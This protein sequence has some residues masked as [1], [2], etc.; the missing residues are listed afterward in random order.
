MVFNLAKL[1][2]GILRKS[3]TRLELNKKVQLM[4]Y[5]V[6]SAAP[7]AQN[8]DVHWPIAAPSLPSKRV[9]GRLVGLFGK[10]PVLTTSRLPSLGILEEASFYSVFNILQQKDERCTRGKTVVESGSELGSV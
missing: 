6:S 4:S 8:V 2:F 5:V 9:D 7:A 3:W 10:A 1:Q